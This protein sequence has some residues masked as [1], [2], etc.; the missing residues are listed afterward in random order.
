M[1]PIFHPHLVF[2]LR[3][4]QG[5]WHPGYRT[6]CVISSWPPS[7]L[8]KWR[9]PKISIHF[10]LELEHETC[11]RSQ[12][13]IP[14]WYAAEISNLHATFFWWATGSYSSCIRWP[15][16]ITTK[17]GRPRGGVSQARKMCLV[18]AYSSWLTV[19]PTCLPGVS[20]SF[21][22]GFDIKQQ[23]HCH[24]TQLLL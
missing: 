9:L 16:Q 3:M 4:A 14:V 20:L 18:K 5:S 8:D 21:P 24:S 10:P 12:Q 19:L 11:S 22:H 23:V 17:M 2:P 1:N 13:F 15:H 7:S 6:P